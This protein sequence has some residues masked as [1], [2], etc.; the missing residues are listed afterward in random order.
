MNQKLNGLDKFNQCS[1]R[2]LPSNPKFIYHSSPEDE[3]YLLKSGPPLQS[4]GIGASQE[5]VYLLT[6]TLEE[7]FIG[8]H[9][10]FCIVRH[11]RSG[12]SKNV[13]IEIDIP[14]GCQRG[15]RIMCRRVG[16]EL[17]NGKL[18]DVAFIIEEAPH[19][20][21]SRLQDDLILEVQLPWSE[22]LKRQPKQVSLRGL[23]GEEIYIH[24]DYVREKML[25]SSLSVRG[26][27]MPI[28][29]GGKVCGRGNLIVQ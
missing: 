11:L 16:H 3:P 2:A 17:P 29:D 28:R 8:K 20:R 10:R 1:D 15:T 5:W 13:M 14:P 12:R 18:Q 25:K 27:G 21:F 26:A 9:C 7:L 24:I 4:L 6:L 19:E 23:D 22:S